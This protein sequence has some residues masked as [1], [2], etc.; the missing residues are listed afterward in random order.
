[1]NADLCFV[2][3][4][5]SSAFIGGYS[6]LC[7]LLWD[8]GQ[9]L[10]IALDATY[11]LDDN[12][13]GVGVYSR[14]I[15]RGLAAAHPETRF[16]WCYRPHRLRRSWKESMPA[17]CRRRLLQEPLAPRGADLFH[18]LNQRLPRARLRHTVATFHALFVLTGEYSTP[19]FRARFAEQARHA[20]QAEAIIAVSEF[21]ARQVHEILGVERQ[22]IHVI[23]HGV[24]LPAAG[25]GPREKMIL[26]VGA[27]QR[28]KN[29]SRLIEAFERVPAPWR[30]VLAGS[31]GFGAEEILQR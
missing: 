17:N 12:L 6:F 28:R 19:E 24:T 14:E 29:L 18:S 25:D 8:I 13:S 15:L 4:R 23:H 11:S 16:L 30:L 21:T 10:T 7:S 22:R 3:H 20:A 9:P 1:M 2:F 5:R 26:H 27:I 31:N